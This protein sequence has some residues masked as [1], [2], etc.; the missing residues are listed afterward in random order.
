MT[1]LKHIQNWPELARQAQWSALALARLCGVS[2]R[3]LER[4]FLEEMGKSPKKWLSEQRQQRAL[5]LIQDGSSVKETAGSLDYKHPSHL[6]NSFKNHFGHF[7]MDK[8]VTT[9]LQNP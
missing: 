6:S 4:H 1:R 2:L 8:S 7:P 9:R 3:T 5:E